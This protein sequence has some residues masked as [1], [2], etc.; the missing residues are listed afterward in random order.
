MIPM[1]PRSHPSNLSPEILLIYIVGKLLLSD[2]SISLHLLHVGVHIL[3]NLGLDS[4]QLGHLDEAGPDDSVA[5][6]C[7]GISSLS[8]LLNFVTGSKYTKFNTSTLTVQISRC[9]FR[10]LCSFEKWVLSVKNLFPPKYQNYIRFKKK[11]TPN[12]DKMFKVDR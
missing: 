11:F 4:L 5:E 12:W 6:S 3:P 1:I 9:P 7:N 2:L 8:N 10:D